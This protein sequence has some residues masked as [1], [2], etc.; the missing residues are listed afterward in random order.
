MIGRFIVKHKDKVYSTQIDRYTCEDVEYYG[1]HQRIKLWFNA[2]NTVIDKLYYDL[3]GSGF[4][5]YNQPVFC[6]MLKKAYILKSVAR[7][8]TAGVDNYVY[9]LT[10]TPAIMPVPQKAKFVPDSAQDFPWL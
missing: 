6:K 9:I 5:K 3:I 8:F 2:D 7:Q 10:L 1:D 4:F